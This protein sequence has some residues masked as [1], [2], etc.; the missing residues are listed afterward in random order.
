MP[1][2][3]LRSEPLAA[4]L[5]VAL[6]GEPQGEEGRQVLEAMRAVQHHLMEPASSFLRGED[7]TGYAPV[8]FRKAFTLRVKY[9]MGGRLKPLS[10]PDE[11]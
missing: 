6:G 10:Y 3:A 7:E 8:P 1:A 11:E 2:V 4:L 5:F 9:Q